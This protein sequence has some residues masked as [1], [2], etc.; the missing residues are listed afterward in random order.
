MPTALVTPPTCTEPKGVI[1]ITSP[2]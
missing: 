2:K 1:T